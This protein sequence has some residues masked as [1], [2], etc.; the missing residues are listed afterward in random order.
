MKNA[1]TSE[2]KIHPRILRRFGFVYRSAFFLFFFRDFRDTISGIRMR[3]KEHFLQK[4]EGNEEDERLKSFRLEVAAMKKAEEGEESP[5][6]KTAHFEGIIPEELTASDY[7]AWERFKQDALTLDDFNE[8]RSDAF[9]SGNASQKNFAAF[10]GN[11]IMLRQIEK[12][13]SE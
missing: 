5:Q 9:R 4:E 2:R 11:K 3:N 1:E 12:E 10:L 7:D 13:D 6:K 8:Y